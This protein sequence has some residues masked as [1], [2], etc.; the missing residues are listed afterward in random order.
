[1]SSDGHIKYSNE[2]GGADP[3]AVN[4]S[5]WTSMSALPALRCYLRSGPDSRYTF[6]VLVGC[7][8]SKQSFLF[9]S[10]VQ[11]RTTHTV[12]ILTTGSFLSQ[13]FK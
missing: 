13:D 12:L 9:L 7:R 3:R 11:V 5:F 10:E 1:M 6:L 4:S 2:D 8:E